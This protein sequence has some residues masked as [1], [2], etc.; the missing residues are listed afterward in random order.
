MLVVLVVLPLFGSWQVMRTFPNHDGAAV[1]GQLKDSTLVAYDSRGIPS[2]TATNDDDVYVAQGYVTAADRLFQMDMLRRQAEGRL[3]QVFGA[4]L[5]STDELARTIGFERQAKIDVEHLSDPTKRALDNYAQGVNAYIN[6]NSDKLPIEFT[7]LCYKPAPWRAADSEAILKY[8]AYKQGESWKLDEFRQRIFNKLGSDI[9]SQIFTED[10]ST[11]LKASSKRAS[12]QPT[13]Q[14]A[15]KQVSESLGRFATSLLPVSESPLR[16][17]SCVAVSGSATEAGGALLACEKHTDFNKPDTYY[18]TY[19]KSPSLHV[20][21][22]TIPGIPGI[23][24]G[25]NENIAFASVNLKADVQDIFLEQFNQ[26]IISQY[27]TDSGWA[28][29]QSLTESIPVRFDKDVLHKI[30]TTRHGPILINT[31]DFAVSLAWSGLNG[32]AL[33]T[34]Q[35]LNKAGDWD[36][37]KQALASY[38]GNPEMFFYADKTGNIGTHVAGAIP[39]RSKGGQGLM[40]ANGWE[41]YGQWMSNLSFTALPETYN[42]K[43]HFLVSANERIDSGFNLVGH[44]FLPPFRHDRAMSLLLATERA[45]HHI[46]LADLNDLQADAVVPL[47]NLVS[48]SVNASVTENRVIDRNELAAVKLLSG[49]DGSAKLD[50]A[51]ACLY[52]GFLHKLAWRILKPK[53]GQEMTNEYLE[54]WP[55]WITFIEHI[56]IERPADWLPPEERTYSTFIV[57]TLGQTITD[58]KV[59][60]NNDNLKQWQWAN[61]HKFRFDHIGA[62]GAPWMNLVLGGP[63]SAMPGDEYTFNAST[64]DQSDSSRTFKST[65]GPCQRLI[66]D[67]ADNNKFYQGLS[68]GES[69]QAFCLYDHD[70]LNSWLHVDPLPVAFSPDTLE[71]QA[72]HKLILVN[73]ATAK[74][75]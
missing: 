71:Q 43:L 38:N 69:G 40:L 25:R 39:Y 63:N 54:K 30:L 50:S 20:A 21:G 74:N 46:Q 61:L 53:L 28:E 44:Q 55:N 36:Q 29:A 32:S 10:A 35:Q 12:T 7:L 18:I 33:D 5:L 22:A 70:Q 27:R 41:P 60:L 24:L 23:M 59:R 45:G 57:T 73:H 6:N 3:S 75:E 56:L 47:Y 14:K 37:F 66:I 26:R 15:L 2:I 1:I 9:Y 49:W 4:S 67:M 52:E 65:A 62:E 17:S 8:L 51:A 64:V 72:Q 58:L 31:S 34:I 11:P 13:E 68:L 16:G 19:L 42:P 48:S